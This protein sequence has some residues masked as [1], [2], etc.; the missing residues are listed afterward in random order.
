MAEPV[1]IL[2]VE[3]NPSDLELTIYAL[4]KEKLARDIQIARD[5]AEALDFLFNRGSSREGERPVM[6]D[7]IFL[8]LKLPKISGLEV[9]REIKS[10]P[11]TR[12]IPVVVI[13]SSEQD[14]DIL[15][16]YGLGA[17]SYITKP[18][19]FE[20]FVDVVGKSGFYWMSINRSPESV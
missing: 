3:D 16:S 18:I 1:R 19:E 11:A 14:V 6:P 7:V 5:G 20:N 17:N 2:L 15:K 4:K 13:T 12:A 10:N 9:L 8:D